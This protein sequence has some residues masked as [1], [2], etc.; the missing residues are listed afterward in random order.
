MEGKH[1]DLDLEGFILYTHTHTH[2]QWKAV[3]SINAYA[4]I[5]FPRYVA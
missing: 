3:M 2:T 5:T 4:I 1:K